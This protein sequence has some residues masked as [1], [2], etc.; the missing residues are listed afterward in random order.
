[1]T[2]KIFTSSLVLV[3]VLCLLAIPFFVVAQN[4]TPTNNTGSPSAQQG[5]CSES[6]TI[7]TCV[8]NIYRWA[9]GAG[10]LLAL[11]MI[12]FAGYRYITAG[13]NAQAVSSA[14][15]IFAGAFIGLIILFAAVVILQTINPDLTN[16]KNLNFSIPNVPANNSNP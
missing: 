7:G 12:I 6:D 11:I 9:L 4:N 14:K 2:K 10:I 15:E 8:I 5:P 16:F 13:G 3:T 1:M